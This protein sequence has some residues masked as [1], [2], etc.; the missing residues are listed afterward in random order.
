MELRIVCI[1]DGHRQGCMLGQGTF[2]WDVSS[3]SK[4]KPLVF[5]S[6]F[7]RFFVTGSDAISRATVELG[8]N[9]STDVIFTLEAGV[10]QLAHVSRIQM[11]ETNQRSTLNTVAHLSPELRRSPCITIIYT[12]IE[13]T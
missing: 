10:N 7:G 8:T 2:G 5:A 4:D 13:P 12:A 11:R 1:A 9:P 3:G 6:Y